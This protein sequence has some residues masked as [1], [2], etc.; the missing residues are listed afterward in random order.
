[1]PNSPLGNFLVSTGFAKIEVIKDG[2]ALNLDT[3]LFEWLKSYTSHLK[4]AADQIMTYQ[5]LLSGDK[6]RITPVDGGF[7]IF[8]SDSLERTEREIPFSCKEARHLQKLLQF[9]VGELLSRI[10]NDNTKYSTDDIDL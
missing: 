10:F 4:N 2:L 3:H 6:I 8:F 7:S 5:L 1:M 9:E